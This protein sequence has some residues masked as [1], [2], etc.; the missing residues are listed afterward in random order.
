MGLANYQ[1]SQLSPARSEDLLRAADEP[2]RNPF[3]PFYQRRLGEFLEK[4]NPGQI[5]F[6]LNF[7]SQALSTFAMAGF[8]KKRD[9]DLDIILGGGLVTSWVRGLRQRN[10]FSGL[11]SKLIAGPGEI[12]ILSSWGI[13]EKAERHFLPD[14]DLLPVSDYLSPGLV[15]PYSTTRG[16]YWNRCLFCPERA[17]G[18]SYTAISAARAVSELGILVEKYHPRLVHLLDNALPPAVLEE[19]AEKPFGAPWYGFARITPHFADL[20]FCLALKRSGCM[21]LQL[22]VESGDQEVL[23]RLQKGIDLETASRALRNLHAAGIAVYVYLLF[24]TPQENSEEARRTLEFTVRHSD[25]IAF[26]NL[27]IFNLPRHGDGLPDLQTTE[28]S[29]GDLSLYTGFSHPQGWNRNEVR[30]F[31]DKEFKR[32]PAVAAILRRDPPIFTSNHA[33]FLTISGKGIEGRG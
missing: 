13:D 29:E 7:L 17:E 22:G 19:I 5:G 18:N 25:E 9:P 31:L 4:T 3:Y 6:S 28:F 14:F 11:I 10:P 16:C 33:A 27:A 26:L 32:H 1:H 21:L 20:G 8:V 30:Q 2:K 24:G 23:D 12:P 15:L